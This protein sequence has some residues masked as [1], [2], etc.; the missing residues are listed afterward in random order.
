MVFGFGRRDEEE[1]EEEEDE[2]EVELVMFQGALN[3]KQPNMQANARLVQAGLIHAKELLTDA[4]QRRAEM[5][6]VEPKG[7][8]AQTALVIDGIAY[9][10]P[11]YPKQQAFAI[12]QVMKLLSGLDIQER[13]LPQSGGVK[14]TL[15][16]ETYEV[17]VATSPGEGG[18]ERLVIKSRNVKSKLD[19]PADLGI[20]DAVKSKIRAL[21]SKKGLFCIVGPPNSGTSTTRFAVARG[22]DTY[23]HQIFTI[24]ETGGRRLDNITAFQK[25]EGDTLEQTLGRVLRVDADIV[26]LDPLTAESV[27]IIWKFIDRA[28]FVT[29]F[30][31]KDT[32]FAVPTLIK[33]VGDGQQ[34][35]DGLNGIMTQKLVRLLCSDCRQAYR[36]N[37]MFLKKVGLPPET[38]VLYRQPKDGD[39]E[40]EDDGPCGKCGGSGYFGRV[41][42]FEL[43][44]VTDGMKPI[45]AKGGDP[46]ALKAQMRSEGQLTLQKDGL[47]LVAEGKTS[48][49]ELQRVFKTA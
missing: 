33:W 48:L 37:P 22:L 31:A 34:V 40:T 12:T 39:E 1:E 5:I 26:I 44:E 36:P 2:E 15:A 11:R 32:A 17:Q 49:E 35:A 16:E 24:G 20:S 10:G 47:R 9:P 46:A 8:R 45:I 14:T 19:T 41:A 23:L 4:I 43:L 3:G 7:E 25:N 13:K 38:K 21:C 42:M 28:A 18:A 30:A 6:R 27:P 29:E